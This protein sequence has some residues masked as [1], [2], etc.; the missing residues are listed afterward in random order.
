MGQRHQFF[1]K[2][3]NPLKYERLRFSKEDRK[4]AK[5]MFGNRKYTIL[6][7]H[8]Q[9]LYGHSAVVNLLNMFMWTKEDTMSEYHNPFSKGFTNFGNSDLE[10]YIKG[11]TDMVTMQPSLLHPR[12]LGFENIIFLNVSEP[13]MRE[14]FDWGDN[15]DGITII[16]TITRKY[17]FM[18][19]YDQDLEEKHGIYTLPSQVP[20]SALAYMKAYYGETVETINPYYTEKQ[21]PEQNN[22][23]VLNNI[24]ENKILNDEVLKHTKGLLTGKMVKRMFPIHYEMIEAKRL[25][26][27]AEA[28]AMASHT[29]FTEQTI[30]NIR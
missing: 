1:I 24:A 4:K 11:I 20:V 25:E 17:C 5:A 22:E 2:V 19:I 14:H 18:N 28:E 3:N 7:F 29:S 15:N 30:E 6:A 9:W 8:H 26:L 13:E 12:G 21:T 23:M 16:D 27:K 10:D